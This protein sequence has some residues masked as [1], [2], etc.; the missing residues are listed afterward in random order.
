MDTPPSLLVKTKICIPALRPRFVS[1]ARLLEQLGLQS[2]TD[3]SLICAPAG[4]GK[5]TLLTEWAHSLEHAGVA[6]AWYSIDPSDDSLLPFATYLVAS[7]EQSLESIPEFKHASQLLR[8]STE[9]NLQRIL[10][11]I[12]NVVASSDR[13]YVLILDDYH[14]ISSPAIHSAIAYLLEHLPAN[15]QLVI[16]SR[17]DPPLPLA[18]LRARGQLHELR[19]SDLRF[20]KEESAQF[21]NEVMR[22]DLTANMV[23]ELETRTE[24]WIAGLQLAALSISG[25]TDKA[26]FIARYTGSHRYLVDYLLEEVVNRQPVEV[27]EF[28]LSTCHLERMCAPLCDA[29]LD[30][31]IDSEATLRKLEQ[32]NVFIVP[33]DDQGTWYRYHHLFRD[34][35]QNRLKKSDL[36]RVGSLN[37]AASEWCSSHNLLRE[38]VQY[39]ISTQDWD[40]A[41]S[42]VEQHSFTMMLHS[43]L[44]TIAEWCLAL[45]DEVLQRHPLLCIMQSWTL[46][47]A[48]RRQ[49]REKIETLLYQAEVTISKMEDKQASQ[50]LADQIAVI[51]TY[52]PLAPDPAVDPG[53]QLILTHNMLAP[54]PKGDPGRFS[55]L[56]TRAYAQMALQDGEA[57]RKILEEARQLAFK[58]QLYFGVIET[59]FHLIRLAHLQGHLEQAGEIYRQCHAD[60]NSMLEHPEQEL[61]ALG[62]LDVALGCVYLEQNRLDE[63]EQSL[64]RGLELSGWGMI[65]FYLMVACLA[66]FRLH[67]IKGRTEKANEV[68]ARLAETWPDIVFFTQSFLIVQKMQSTPI[69]PAVLAK[70][71]TWC[72]DFTSSMD[73]QK[74]VPGIGPLG[75]TEAYYLSYLNWV[76][77]QIAL[78]NPSV[79]L[80]YL[81][82][83]LPIAQANSLTA[84]SIELNLM[85]AQVRQAEGDNNQAMKALEVAL[86]D[87][88]SDGFIRSFDQGQVLNELLHQA[89]DQGICGAYTKEIL[90]AIEY[91]RPSSERSVGGANQITLESGEH[92]SQREIEVLRL[93]A[94]G[95]S[96]QD[97]SEK[98]FIT[99]GTV[100]SHINHI[101]VK[102]E[103]HNRTEAVARVR[104][105]GILNI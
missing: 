95:A 26:D 101:L 96:N 30:N 4:Y 39:A 52:L 19:A 97:I 67:Q 85:L 73:G 5:S 61:P 21:L 8:S 87:A 54:T 10:P 12:I 70:A 7:L 94:Q 14:L 69:N 24:G 2:G 66:L 45:P 53:A 20:T 65:P 3:L 59:T 13:E 25:A 72:D 38:A 76:R 77:I 51:R 64:L 92:L 105:S 55:I 102:L 81:E 27:Q 99:I 89:V 47:L 11:D 93:M 41:A 40:Y 6:V 28:L 42:M 60:I 78:K 35:L 88:Q 57:A 56:L 68:L 18:R 37:H 103:A 1:R 9:V 98:L 43:E 80:G 62:C 48:F 46:V 71:A 23:D 29:I 49:N 91:T 83:Q 74:I 33:L 31:R 84:R 82:Q 86:T 50:V 63:A 104:E 44:F 16:G 32:A 90:K 22:L 17:S 36:K 34:F 15:M 79:T 75:V 58:G 100:K